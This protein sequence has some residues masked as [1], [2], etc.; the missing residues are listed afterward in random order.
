MHTRPSLT[1]AAAGLILA[2]ASPAHAAPFDLAAA[3]DVA[4][5]G[6]TIT[7]PDGSYPGQFVLD[8]PGVTLTGGPGAILDGG[9]PKKGYALHVTGADGARVQGLTVTGGQKGVMVD[10]SDD[11]VIDGITAHRFGME[12]VHFRNGS[13][14]G[15]LRGSTIGDTGLDKAKF[16]ECIYVG[17]AESNWDAKTSL[18]GGAPDVITGALIEGNT[19]EA[20]TAEA[21]DVKEGTDGVVIRGNTFDGAGITGDHFADSYIDFKGRNGQAV[22]NTFTNPSPAVL[23]VL[24]QHSIV[25]E[26][27]G[28]NT[29]RDNT[30]PAGLSCELAG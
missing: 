28:G 5:P 11:V 22:G 12:G 30:C 15:V 10:A 21:V 2:A 20:F 6:Q 27:F 1:I 18:T 8:V 14:R 24:Q 17:T 9:S 7:V 26:L 29:A 16:G 23:D 3:L 13:D 4:Q 25:D 19:C